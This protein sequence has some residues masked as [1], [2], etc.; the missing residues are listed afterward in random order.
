MKKQFDRQQ[1]NRQFILPGV[2]ESHFVGPVIATNDS[3]NSK[4]NES[5]VIASL[6]ANAAI[7][8]E[9]NEGHNDVRTGNVL[10]SLEGAVVVDLYHPSTSNVNVVVHA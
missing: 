9:C 5:V 6:E 4:G 7:E 1:F 8:P 3:E 2:V 10:A